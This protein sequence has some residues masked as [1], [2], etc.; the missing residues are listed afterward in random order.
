MGGLDVFDSISSYLFPDLSTHSASF[1][2]MR[3]YVDGEQYGQKNGQGFYE[4]TPEFSKQM[5]QER[6]QE[7]I[8]WLKKDRRK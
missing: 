3:A 2:K 4:W 5:N 7:L 1:S 6:E 8:D